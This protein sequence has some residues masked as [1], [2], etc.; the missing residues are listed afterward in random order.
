MERSDKF[1]FPHSDDVD[2]A[3]DV[4]AWGVRLPDGLLD[5]SVGRK[6]IK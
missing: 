3:V 1:F 4:Q 6:N 5:N 2:V